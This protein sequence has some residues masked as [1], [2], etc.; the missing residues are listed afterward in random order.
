[1]K[2]GQNEFCKNEI[3]NKACWRFISINDICQTIKNFTTLQLQSVGWAERKYEHISSWFP[4]QINMFL[5]HKYLSL[6]PGD[7]LRSPRTPD[8]GRMC[9]QWRWPAGW[10]T[11]LWTST[12]TSVESL[13]NF[14]YI[15][16]FTWTALPKQAILVDP[17][18][19]K[20]DNKKWHFL[21]IWL[22]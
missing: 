8:T 20:F 14:N 4:K 13:V 12:H 7:S 15:Y 1:M 3:I 17:F 5:F 22:P 11:L 19:Q 18:L 2:D 16:H 21:I 10:C 6:I 9:R